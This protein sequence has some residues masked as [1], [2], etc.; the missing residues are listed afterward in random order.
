MKYWELH[1][2]IF[3]RRHLHYIASKDTYFP[4]PHALADFIVILGSQEKYFAAM[5]TC[6]S[7]RSPAKFGTTHVK[8]GLRYIAVVVVKSEYSFHHSKI[9]ISFHPLCVTYSVRW[10][11][12]KLYDLLFTKFDNV[13]F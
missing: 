3:F 5:D 12:N 10:Y 1:F 6:S 13:Q 2:D 7:E 9:S 8:L 4:D 11:N